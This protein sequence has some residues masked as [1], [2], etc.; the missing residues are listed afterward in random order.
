MHFL[1]IENKNKNGEKE[2]KHIET[3]SIGYYFEYFTERSLEKYNKDR[4]GM[5][6]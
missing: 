2:T 3:A 5:W 4:E 6:D 1:P